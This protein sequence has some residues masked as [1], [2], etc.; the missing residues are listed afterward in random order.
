MI[1]TFIK[2]KNKLIFIEKGNNNNLNDDLV[3]QLLDNLETL[4]NNEV[5]YHVAQIVSTYVQKQQLEVTY[6]LIQKE[7]IYQLIDFSLKKKNA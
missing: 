7:L 3:K 4:T 1:Q 5:K 2:Q 6:K